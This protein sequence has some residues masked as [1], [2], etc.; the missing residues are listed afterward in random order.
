VQSHI[1][2]TEKTLQRKALIEILIRS[3]VINMKHPKSDWALTD[4]GTRKRDR[5]VN[6][7]KVKK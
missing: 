5:Y 7:V 6:I 4:V 1:N 3:P 2:H